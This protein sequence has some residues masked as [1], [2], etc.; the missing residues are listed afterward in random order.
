MKK[1]K[2][3]A[4]LKNRMKGRKDIVYLSRGARCPSLP[5]LG[6]GVA[7]GLWGRASGREV[8]ERTPI[9]TTLWLYLL[10]FRCF[11]STH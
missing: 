3:E 5:E 9:F 10:L 2:T 7:G 11:G 4:S 6:E 8:A 1:S